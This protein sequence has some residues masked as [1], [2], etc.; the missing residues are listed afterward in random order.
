[1][2][3]REPKQTDRRTF[4]KLAGLGAAGASIGLGASEA[5]AAE[6]GATE[7]H[8]GYQ[9]TEHVKAYYKMARF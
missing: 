8:A 7:G 9:E 3:D 4:M 6:P 1:M 2:T 5:Q